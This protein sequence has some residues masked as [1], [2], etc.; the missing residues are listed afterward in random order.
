VAE[1]RPGAEPNQ[2]L[3]TGLGQGFERSPITSVAGLA[4][5]LAAPEFG[6]GSDIRHELPQVS[7]P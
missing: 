3:Q 7:G 6:P 5:G 2:L 4:M 1:S